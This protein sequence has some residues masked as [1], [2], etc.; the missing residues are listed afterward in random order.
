MSLQIPAVIGAA[1]CDS[2]PRERL[3]RR[4][5]VYKVHP[6]FRNR[7]SMQPQ[8]A[9]SPSKRRAIRFW[10]L[11]VAGL[12]FVMV[13]VG[14]ATRVTESG[15]SIVEWKPITGVVPP[16]TAAQWRSEFE[17][18]QAIPQY[19]LM[20]LAMS[21]DEFKTIYWWEWAHRLLGR[22]IGVAFLLPFLWFW[23]QGWITRPLG[24]RLLMIFGL[25]GLQGAVGWWMVASGLVE[26]VEVSQYR[27]A[28]H[29]LLACLIFV[30]VLWTALE[31]EIRATLTV[32]AHG[33]RT[34]AA[35]LILALLQIYIGAL[36]AGL[37]GGL[38]YNTWPFIDG[39]LFPPIT[40]LF[41]IDPGW[42]NLF[43][44]VLTVQFEHRMTAYAL[45]VGALWHAATAV[46]LADRAVA[47][48]AIALATGVTVQACLGI[49]TLVQQAP[50][51]LALLHQAMAIVV[52][53][54]AV[55]NAQ[56]LW[57]KRAPVTVGTVQPLTSSPQA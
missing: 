49:L 53:S 51:P 45:W 57:G 52:L 54:L 31:L 8:F 22:F 43:E 24:L 17:T 48:S 1:L 44:N 3:Q 34:A 32:P 12:V 4:R 14:G 55:V 40:A 6:I 29:L 15:L 19:R 30:A 7:C 33:R 26:R 37:R 2:V 13:V 25:G 47:I 9:L 20:N 18:Y 16:L 35:L 38:I 39:A 36:L 5:L 50:P 28:T 21:L 27:L 10:L 41:S 56:R 42:R 46:R 23:R 11:A